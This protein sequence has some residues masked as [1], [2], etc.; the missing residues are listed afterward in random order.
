MAAVAD[1]DLDATI[2]ACLDTYLAALEARGAR[3]KTV[4]HNRWVAGRYLR[5]QLGAKRVQKITTA[6]VRKILRGIAHPSGWTQVKIVQVMREG[7]RRRRARGRAGAL[8][9]GEA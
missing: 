7:V 2:D 5:D 9:A 4:R 3:E 6:D 8:A 1:L